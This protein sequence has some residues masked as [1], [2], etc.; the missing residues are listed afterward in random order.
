V[1][2]ISGTISVLIKYKG[3][4]NIVVDAIK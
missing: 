1:D 3:K 2:G 4:T